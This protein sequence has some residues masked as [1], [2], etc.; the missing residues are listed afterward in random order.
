M[1]GC[2]YKNLTI[3]FNKFHNLVDKDV[4]EYGEYCLLE[5]KDGRLTG[6]SWNPSDWEHKTAEGSFI[7]GTGETVEASE[8]ARWHSLDKDTIAGC[9]EKDGVNYIDIGP[10]TDDGSSV[11]LEGFKSFKDKDYPKSEQFCF[12]IMKNG[13]LAAGRWDKLDEED[14]D[15]VYG[16]ALAS[17]NMEDVWAWAPLSSDEFF[18]MEQ[19]SEREEK[20]EEEMNL[21]PSTDKKKFKYGTDIEVYYDKALE[22]LLVKYPWATKNQMKKVT[23]WEITPLHGKNVFGQVST[24]Y[25][26][27]RIVD[28]WTDGESADE[29]IDFLC[30]YTKRAVENSNPEE[31]FKYGTDIKVYLQKAFDEVKKEY[32]WLEPQML[33]VNWHY[34]IQKI[35]GEWEFVTAYGDSYKYYIRECGSADD[36][37]KTV[38]SD[39]QVEALEANPVVDSYDVPFGHV[40]IHGWNLERYRVYKLKSGDYKVSVQAGDRVTGG[41]REFF[42]TPNCFKTKSYETFLDRYLEIVPGEHF[43]LKKKDLLADEKLKKFLGFK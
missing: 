22:K 24:G 27:A 40:E 3:S 7:R 20:L 19:E 17:H 29:F 1:K 21:N 14:G 23:P 26:N 33:E 35:N 2:D 34:D 4:P 32:S 43:G 13:D 10:E 41:T 25:K 37:I 12:L 42:I 31:K 6:G 15:F 38:I 9:L 36:F 11:E 39:Y 8:V 28:E 16:S 18:E 5:L 30:E